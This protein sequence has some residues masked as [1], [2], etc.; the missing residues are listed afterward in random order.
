MQLHTN[1]EMLRVYPAAIVI[2]SVYFYYRCSVFLI[3]NE[4]DELVSKVFDGI[5]ANDSE[6]IVF[7]FV[8]K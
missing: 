7:S 5:S 1:I 3:D 8:K 6:V 2:H 4:T